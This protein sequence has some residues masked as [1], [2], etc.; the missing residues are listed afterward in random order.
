MRFTAHADH[1]AD[2]SQCE[3]CFL[4]IT[5]NVQGDRGGARYKMPLMKKS[6]YRHHFLTEWQAA[7]NA[8][9]RIIV[10]GLFSAFMLQYC[11]ATITIYWLCAVVAT[12]VV[13]I[14]ISHKLPVLWLN[15]IIW[16]VSGI[17]IWQDGGEIPHVT[18]AIIEYNVSLY[19][20]AIWTLL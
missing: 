7:A 2:F 6:E 10:G 16:V 19:A 11:G 1:I 20:A 12:E 13:A 8:L 9:F 14:G 18:F 4:P 3:L 17:L 15:A 5:N